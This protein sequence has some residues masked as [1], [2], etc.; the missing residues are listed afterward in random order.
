MSMCEAMPSA[1]IIR[2]GLERMQLG[3]LPLL[4]APVFHPAINGQ[5]LNCRREGGLTTDRQTAGNQHETVHR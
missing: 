4:A 2:S 3:A 1:I 5:E